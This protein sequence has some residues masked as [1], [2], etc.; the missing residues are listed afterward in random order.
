V[1]TT[2]KNT[3]TRT[4]YKQV[5]T[6]ALPLRCSEYYLVTKL[7]NLTQLWVSSSW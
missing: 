6:R 3:S 4:V 5:H 1:L 2:E 7:I